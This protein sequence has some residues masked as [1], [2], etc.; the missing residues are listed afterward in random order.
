MGAMAFQIVIEIAHSHQRWPFCTI[1]RFLLALMQL[2]QWTLHPDPLFRARVRDLKK[3]NWITQPVQIEDYLWSEVLPNYGMNE[4][5]YAL[6]CLLNRH[7]FILFSRCIKI[8]S[9]VNII[10]KR[11]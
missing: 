1:D 4:H 9:S 3:H 11:V 10:K 8:F 7:V 2:I 6:L 5:V